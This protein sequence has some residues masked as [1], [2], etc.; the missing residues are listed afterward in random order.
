[1]KINILTPFEWKN[2][3]KA[4]R[5]GATSLE[6]F[7]LESRRRFSRKNFSISRVNRY[8]LSNT[9]DLFVLFQFL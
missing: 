9:K 4:P 2:D 6:T 8:F 5:F 1:M 7:D 3:V